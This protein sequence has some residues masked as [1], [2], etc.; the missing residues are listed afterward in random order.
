MG[1]G[2]ARARRVRRLGVA[3]A[4]AC[5]LIGLPGLSGPSGT[6]RAVAADPAFDAYGGWAGTTEVATGFFRTQ[7][8]D[9]RWWLIDPEGHPFFSN[10]INHVVP[11][12]TPDRNGHAAY[13]EAILA[14]HGTE[15]AWADAQ[16]ER[17][18]RW[19]TNTLGG[20][21]DNDL[22]AGRGV[23]YTVLF[24]FAGYGGG[25]VDDFWDPAWADGVAASAQ[26]A[27]VEH[28]GDPWLV[29]YFLDNEVPWTDDWRPGPFSGFFGRGAEEP[30][31]QHLVAWLEA[32]YGGFDAF[33]LDF[34]TS[35]TG[36]SDLAAAT[37]ATPIGPGAQATKDAWSGEVAR[38][39]FGVTGAALRAADPDHLNLGAR[40]V[41]QLITPEVLDA[42]G[43][44]VDVVSV[45]WYEIKDSWKEL[46]GALGPDFLSTDDTLAA[47]RSLVDRPFLISEFG[48]RARDS[49]L[50][51][52]Y[53]PLQVVVDT[54]QDR[55]DNYRNFGSCLVNTGDVVG[56][57]WFEMT[58]EPAIG[59]FDGEDDNWGM[60]TEADD[61]YEVVV[62]SSA[63]VHA[64]AYAPLADPS[65][66]PGA[67]TPIS[68]RVAPPQPTSTTAATV[69]VSST[70]T[71]TTAD[72]GAGDTAVPAVPVG[73]SAAYTG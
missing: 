36:W 60:V 27:A 48:W 51:N 9:G 14:K 32:R 57:H 10:G 13:H 28:A 7:Q 35:A 19:G 40:F 44:D 55:A 29:G 33:A 42:A 39:F 34:A 49:G 68:D 16:V 11:E 46:I 12:G 23:P 71:T 20:W 61:E 25:R 67:C 41:G 47:H 73:G 56:A 31:K 1:E 3:A 50:P 62:A 54:Q 70:S 15:E 5:A 53:P 69:P 22:F 43:A 26:A 72:L 30:G 65:W 6:G 66:S 38:R 2:R 8:V 64:A 24:G 21:S 58:D 18:D 63:D 37:A 59:R 52:T 17:F 45:N 4:C